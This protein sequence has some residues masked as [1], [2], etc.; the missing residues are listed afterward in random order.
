MNPE[1][2]FTSLGISV[3]ACMFLLVGAVFYNR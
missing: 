1:K 2:I 3:L